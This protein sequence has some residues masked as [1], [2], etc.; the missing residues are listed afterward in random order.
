MSQQ[1]DLNESFSVE[2]HSKPDFYQECQVSRLS[3]S[4]N[5]ECI[6]EA[7]EI[8]CDKKNTNNFDQ[9]KSVNNKLRGNISKIF[10]LL[11]DKEIHMIQN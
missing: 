3:S 4:D 9:L 1:Y 5:E 11:N 8:N 7:A 6:L 2:F 10:D